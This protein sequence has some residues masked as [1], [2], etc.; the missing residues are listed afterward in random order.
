MKASLP[1]VCVCVCA[2]VRRM[3]VVLQAPANSISV[4]AD[5]DALCHRWQWY[6]GWGS[7]V[8]Q[9]DSKFCLLWLPLRTA[10]QRCPTPPLQRCLPVGH[11]VRAT[12]KQCQRACATLCRRRP[13]SFLFLLFLIEFCRRCVVC[14]RVCVRGGGKLTT[15]A[16][17]LSDLTLFLFSSENGTAVAGRRGD[18]LPE[19]TAPRFFVHM[20]KATPCVR[21]SSAV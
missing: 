19:P 17:A 11:P 1:L 16:A 10:L 12:T 6:F 5:S 4:C 20:C 3:C 9:Q 2:C 7:E 15:M 14:V 13:V 18:S 8:R 21:P